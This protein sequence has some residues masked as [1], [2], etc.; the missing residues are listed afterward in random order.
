MTFLN[1][2]REEMAPF[3]VKHYIEGL[4]IPAAFHS[5]SDIDHGD[6]HDHP[7]AFT[8][9]IVAGGYV[10]EV[11]DRDG[12]SHFVEHLPGESFRVEANHIHRVVALPRGECTTIAIPGPEVQKSGFYQFR[13]DGAYRRDHDGD[14][15]FPDGRGKSVLPGIAF[16]YY[17][18]WLF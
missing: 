12:T 18:Q 6:P 7:W 9:F 13:A 3:F 16:H 10:E 5:F 11:F 17:R 14:R 15:A 1:L 8:S 2:R 4:P